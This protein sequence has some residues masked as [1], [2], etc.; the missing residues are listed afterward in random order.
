MDLF[1]DRLSVTLQLPSTR[2][3]AAIN[4]NR[5]RWCI[6]SHLFN[7]TRIL[8]QYNGLQTTERRFFKSDL[9]ESDSVAEHVLPS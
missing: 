1:L 3:G 5:K 7:P 8:A 2:S 9:K 6:E 4:P